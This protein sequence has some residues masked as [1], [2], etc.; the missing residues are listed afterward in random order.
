MPR[1]SHFPWLII[2]RIVCE[3]H[4]LWSSSFWNYLQPPVTAS[5]LGRS[6]FSQKSSNHI[7]PSKWNTKKVHTH[8]HSTED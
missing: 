6:T 4:K 3:E 5:L 1:P 2:L 8:R 7:L